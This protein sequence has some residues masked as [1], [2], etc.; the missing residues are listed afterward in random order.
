[1][2]D[3]LEDVGVQQSSPARVRVPMGRC[4][5]RIST[6]TPEDLAPEERHRIY[7]LLWLSVRSR[8]D[9]P[10]EVSGIFA[11]VAEEAENG[12]SYCNFSSLSV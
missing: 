6:E 8:P 1:M 10:L 12:L 4:A 7:K 5:R 2:V 11:E 3:F 9:W